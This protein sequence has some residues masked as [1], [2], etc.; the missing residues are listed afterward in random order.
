MTEDNEFFDLSRLK[1]NDEPRIIDIEG[2]GKIKYCPLTAIDMVK[3]STEA[4]ADEDV[5]TFGFRATFA[6][7][8]KANPDMDYESWKRSSP[9]MVNKLIVAIMKDSDF[10]ESSLVGQ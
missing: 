2:M 10:L 6:M 1:V 7:L 4:E 3:M 8:K 5:E 9:K